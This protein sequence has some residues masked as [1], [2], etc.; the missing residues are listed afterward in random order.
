MRT[1]L[2]VRGRVVLVLPGVDSVEWPGARA[3]EN[4]GCMPV[5]VVNSNNARAPHQ[6]MTASTNP[7]S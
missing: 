5:R 6:M 7:R 4:A 1:W 2:G 3:K